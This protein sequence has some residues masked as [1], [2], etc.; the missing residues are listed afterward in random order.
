MLTYSLPNYLN[1]VRNLVPAWTHDL[2]I[3]FCCALC[4]VNLKDIFL[5]VDFSWD[6]CDNNC[7]VE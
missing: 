2:Y 7:F 6:Y 4:Q 1:F 3:L 5:K